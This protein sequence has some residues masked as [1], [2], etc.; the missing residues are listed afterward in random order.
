MKQQVLIY[1]L[2]MIS[3]SGILMGS[4]KESKRSGQSNKKKQPNGVPTNKNNNATSPQ[5]AQPINGNHAQTQTTSRSSAQP[6]ATTNGNHQ[7]TSQPSGATTQNSA[8]TNGHHQQQPPRIPATTSNGVGHSSFGRVSIIDEE[9]G[10]QMPFYNI[11]PQQPNFVVPLGMQQQMPMP[12]ILQTGPGEQQARDSEFQ[13][14]EAVGSIVAAMAA[15]E[16]ARE[17]INAKTP[18]QAAQEKIDDINRKR[19][20]DLQVWPVALRQAAEE[21]ARFTQPL[22]DI[23]AGVNLTEEQKRAQLQ[24]EEVIH[25]RNLRNAQRRAEINAVTFGSPNQ[26][27]F[28][29]IVV[30]SAAQTISD[31]TRPM[32]AKLISEKIPNCLSF[33][34]NLLKNR[35]KTPLENNNSGDDEPALSPKEFFALQ[36]GTLATEQS[37][38]NLQLTQAQT[39]KLD[40]ETILDL[41]KMRPN[42]PL[43]QNIVSTHMHNVAMVTI[44]RHEA[45][46]RKAQAQQAAQKAAQQQQQSAA[47]ATKLELQPT[48]SNQAPTKLAATTPPTAAAA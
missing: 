34:W 2:I 32:L 13:T 47:P 33:L 9:S 46:V 36:Q 28:R 18:R 37:K 23:A 7:T 17:L 20:V 31:V 3:G 27:M 1:T 38:A 26:Q 12:F 30:T 21:Q 25:Q 42:D 8:S 19:E 22:E 45:M 15:Q 29:Q 6:A 41:Q 14:T 24:R 44:G 10:M 39:R 35:G 4:G 43:L 48:A 11:A 16:V 40:G 5:P